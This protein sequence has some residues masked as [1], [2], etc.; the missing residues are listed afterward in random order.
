MRKLRDSHRS[1]LRA[2]GLA[3]A[4]AVG[5]GLSPVTARAQDDAS[6][7]LTVY[8]L[9]FA[10]V[11][12]VRVLDLQDGTQENPY[13][14]I[15]AG[16]NAATVLDLVSVAP[17]TYP[18]ILLMRSGIEVECQSPPNCI[19]D[20]TGRNRPAVVFDQ[21]TGSPRL[22]G[23]TVTGGAGRRTENNKCF[24]LDMFTCF[25]SLNC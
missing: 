8:N 13:L 23:F 21:L 16:V 5:T 11:K 17:G 20:A 12:D 4:V 18:E 1:K 6:V 19:I 10:L 22:E 15:K 14:S 2:L 24:W 3:L 25:S 9:N 7:S